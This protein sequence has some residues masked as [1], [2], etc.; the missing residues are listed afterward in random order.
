MENKATVSENSRRIARN[1]ALL[2]VRMT[3]MLIVGLYTSR[4]ILNA[5]GQDDFG[6]YGAV[7]GV[8]ALF[9]ILTGSV[10]GAISRFMSFELGKK[11]GRMDVVFS[12]TFFIQ[13]VMALGVLL[14]AEGLG[15]WFLNA[16]MVIPEGR[17]G[18]ANLVLQCSIFMFV[19]NMLAVPYNAAIIA[20]EKM[21]AFAYISIA[22]ALLALGAAIATRYAGV[23]K[24]K[25]YALLML[26]VALIVRFLYAFYA[27]KNFEEC[28]FR[29]GKVSKPLIKEMG[30]YTGWTMLGSASNVI[31]TQGINVLMNLFFGVRV[32]AARDVA[33]KLEGNVSRFIFNITTAVNPQI[34]KSYAAGNFAYLHQLV[35]KGARYSYFLF[36]FFAMPLILEA[37]AL[38][39]LWLG[40]VPA[41]SVEFVRISLLS[42][43]IVAVG[44]PFSAAIFASGKVKAYEIVISATCVLAFP[45]AWA[46]YK[47]GYPPQLAYWIIVGTSVL[48]LV[49]RLLF[50]QK[51]VGL[52]LSFLCRDLLPKLL[53]GT[54][55]SLPV[56]L[57]LHY[58][59]EP[60]AA[61]AVWVVL[62][63][64]ATTA[65]SVYLLGAT[66]GEREVVNGAL[67][68]FFSRKR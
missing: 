45:L 33:V 4:V 32:N 25:L 67:K 16:K 42:S 35:S 47:L 44:N 12:T 19:L 30:S 31:N 43:L 40:Q 61:R 58:L 65:L 28:R 53:L 24:L 15:V 23:D 9:G 13:I 22:E 68:R 29:A 52:K 49:E 57:L 6:V 59:L 7:G 36:Y 27:K 60:S 17:M 18:A 66:P 62:A 54:I 64:F 20:H 11:D 50:T 51:L 55:V 10:A 34:N 39:Q 3:V 46:A 48:G 63:A 38:L 1:T 26:A 8:V 2:Y 5:L 21:E 14:L 37:P 56:P 41:Y